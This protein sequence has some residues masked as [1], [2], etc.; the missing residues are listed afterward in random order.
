MDV[1]VASQS[2]NER[3]LMPQVRLQHRLRLL[4]EQ[5]AR[6]DI[7]VNAHMQTRS[8]TI[9]SNTLAA[10]RILM[11]GLIFQPIK[12]LGNDLNSQISA[13]VSVGS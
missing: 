5:S 9:P 10:P 1:Q 6:N 3:G 13:V 12:T 8:R 7:I 4:L 2:V 11:W